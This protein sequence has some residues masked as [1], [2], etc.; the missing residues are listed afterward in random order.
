MPTWPTA[1]GFPQAPRAF[2]WK[3]QHQD[4][5]AEFKPEVGPA[6]LRKRVTG[7]VYLCSAS[8]QL[9][10]AQRATLE[11]FWRVDCKEGSL[12][13]QWRDPD[14]PT[15]IRTWEWVER[16]SITHRTGDIFVAAIQL[17]RI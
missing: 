14:D 10:K 12:S 2:S 3:R 15:V 5:V 9:T 4:I 11:A 8:F 16:P 1:G 13:F 7:G 17:Y 6:R